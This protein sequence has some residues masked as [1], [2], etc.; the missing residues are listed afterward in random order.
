LE[1]AVLGRLVAVE[2]AE[3]LT[4]DGVDGAADGGVEGPQLRA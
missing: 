1:A 4:K 2:G 3:A